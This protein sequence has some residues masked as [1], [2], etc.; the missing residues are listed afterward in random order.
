MY[1]NRVYP[2]SF[3]NKPLQLHIITFIFSP[4]SIGPSSQYFLEEVSI[5]AYSSVIVNRESALSCAAE[6]SRKGQ[7]PSLS[8]V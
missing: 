4:F 8:T 1:E 3:K 5:D 2:L 7:F 6:A